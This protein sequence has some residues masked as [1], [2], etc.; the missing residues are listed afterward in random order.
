MNDNCIYEVKLLPSQRLKLILDLLKLSYVLI[1]EVKSDSTNK[2]K[3]EVSIKKKLNHSAGVYLCVNL[4]N[5]KLYVGSAGLGLIYR[6]YLAHIHLAK[7]GSKLV[8]LAVKKYGQENFAFVVL[9]NTENRKDLILEREQYYINLLDPG[10]N[11]AKIAGSAI[12][13]RRSI[14]QR[15]RQSINISLE[16][17]ERILAQL[18]CA[19]DKPR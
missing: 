4:I 9:E 5:Q 8:N 6:R 7:G 14:E 19:H 17:I 10:Y 12:G 11:L 18:R 13:T 16:Q 3:I 15:R 1:L 2:D